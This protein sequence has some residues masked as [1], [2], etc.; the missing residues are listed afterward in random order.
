[1][2]DPAHLQMIISAIKIAVGLGAMVILLG[3]IENILHI[4]KGKK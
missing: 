1:M 2:I 4:F 3:L